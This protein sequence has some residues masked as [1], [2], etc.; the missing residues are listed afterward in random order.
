MSRESKGCKASQLSGVGSYP[1]RRLSGHCMAQLC[2]QSNRHDSDSC[3][4]AGHEI[5]CFIHCAG[6]VHGL[7]CVWALNSVLD[8][9]D[10]VSVRFGSCCTAY[11]GFF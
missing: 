3:R 1:N 10:V 2:C 7:S 5:I 8:A 4:H 6:F 11:V 9:L